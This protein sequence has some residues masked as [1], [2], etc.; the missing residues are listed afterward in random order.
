MTPL[1][2]QA[3]DA[4][5]SVTGEPFSC[6]VCEGR[7]CLRYHSKE[8]SFRVK[9]APEVVGG[10]S[11]TKQRAAQLVSRRAERRPDAVPPVLVARHITDAAAALLRQNGVA[12]VDTAGNCYLNRNGLFVL[13]R[14]LS[15]STD[16]RADRPI[17]AFQSSGLRLIFHLLVHDELV[18]EPYRTLATMAQISRGTV[19]YIMNDLQT[20]GFVEEAQGTRRLRNRRALLDRWTPAF[21][22]RLR[23]D[24]LRGRFRFI[25]DPPSDWKAL[26]LDASTTLWGGEPAADLLTDG[27]R[28]SQF[29]LYSREETSSLCYQLEAIPDANG[30]LEILDRFWDPSC[31]P[32]LRERADRA[33]C[34]PPLLAYADLIAAGDPRGLETAD[35]IYKRYLSDE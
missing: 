35:V 19:G 24:L 15:S 2:R 21:A 33:P 12:Y 18:A 32:N 34:V 22:E 6:V 11:V 4:L 7:M 27:L 28:P 26:P 16:K 31:L 25:A 29:T 8:A 5:S 10:E 13:I 3:V 14:G 1:L 20:L 23:P 17:R 30:S 9:E